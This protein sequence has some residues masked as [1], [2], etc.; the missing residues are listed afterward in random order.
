M[1]IAAH[2]RGKLAA[3]FLRH[4]DSLTDF[5][6][7]QIMVYRIIHTRFESPG[8]KLSDLQSQLITKGPSRHPDLFFIIPELNSGKTQGRCLPDS[9]RKIQICPPHLYIDGKPGAGCFS[10]TAEIF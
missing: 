10:N 4:F 1:I 9:V 7:H 2:H 6:L 8:N 3:Q 5:I